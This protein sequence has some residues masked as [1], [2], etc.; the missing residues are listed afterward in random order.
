MAI[1]NSGGTSAQECSRAAAANFHLR[2]SGFALLFLAGCAA[3]GEPQP[4]QPPIPAAITDL[5][6]NQL[7]DSV[8]LT[9][10][11]P[12]NATSGQRLIEPPAIEIYRGAARPDGSPD[13]KSLRLVYTIPG[14]VVD[15]YEQEDRVHF[16][17]PISSEEIRAHPG[18][19]LVYRVRARVSKKR[20][21][22]DSNT[23]RVRVFPAPAKITDLQARVTETAIELS[24]SVPERTTAGDA[25]PTISGY[26][27]YRG[28]LDAASVETAQKDFTQASWKKPLSL[29]GPTT[30]NRFRDTQFEFGTS[31]AYVVRSVIVADGNTAESADSAPVIITPRDTFPPAVPQ[32]LVAVYL[33]VGTP[34]APRVELSW[35]MNVETDLAGYRVYRSE[36][37]GT[38]GQLVTPD[39]LPAPAFRDISVDVGHHYWYTVTAV[40][41]A[42]NESEASAPA[43]V[44]VTQP[45]PE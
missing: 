9:F 41:R 11:P 44:E 15:T 43:S 13:E 16:V 37:E 27:I 1:R 10:T 32:G 6:A 23:V 39:L 21:S 24:W 34:P 42:G 38:R 20:A 2:I 7:G 17:D 3:P 30:T 14:A 19:T 31:Y 40:D 4:P 8:A 18:E 5:S 29:L 26:R 45:S 25:A 35:S 28:E 33:T 12:R 22:A 36:Q